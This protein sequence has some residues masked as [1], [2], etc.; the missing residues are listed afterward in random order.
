[1]LHG[2]DVLKGTPR[3]QRNAR[4]RFIGNR[5]WQACRLAQ[6]SIKIMQQAAAAGH[7]NAL[8]DNV[9]GEF[10]RCRL[11]RHLNR[12]NNSPNRLGK[13]FGNFALCQ[14]HFARHAVHQIAALDFDR[15]AIFAWR[16][17]RRANLLFDTLRARLAKQHN[18]ANVICIGERLTGPEVAKDCVDAYLA[19]EFEGGR[20][21][22]R[23]AK[24]DSLGGESA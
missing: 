6:I 5:H 16:H 12:F 17:H 18:D 20:H 3:A 22:G 2:F 15:R 11:K 7:N 1:M 10:R 23:V 4:K 9:S 14:R 21:E 19:A 24:L 13:T 8:I